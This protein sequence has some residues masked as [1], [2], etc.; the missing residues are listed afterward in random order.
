MTNLTVY[1][2]VTPQHRRISEVHWPVRDPVSQNKLG[3]RETAYQ[4]KVLAAKPDIL[5]SKPRPTFL[6]RGWGR[7]ADSLKV[8]FDLHT[9]AVASNKK[10]IKGGWHM[11]NNTRSWPLV[12]TGVHTQTHTSKPVQTNLYMHIHTYTLTYRYQKWGDFCVSYMSL[13]NN[14]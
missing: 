4:V 6:G 9:C 5:S 7:E 8:P 10:L 13:I 14:E 11:K 3:A 2:R 12:S 1:K